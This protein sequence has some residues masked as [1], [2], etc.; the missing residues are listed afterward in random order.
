MSRRLPLRWVLL[1]VAN[2][3]LVC[4]L[5]FYRSTSAAPQTS[6]Q[7]FANSVQQRAEMIEQLKAISTEM[8]KLRAE[9]R[10]QNTLL[11]SGRVKVT[12][13]AGKKP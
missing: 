1:I 7:P 10:A 6:R 12:I 5:G 3:S 11:Q 13:A 8:Q 2:V 9:L 4:M